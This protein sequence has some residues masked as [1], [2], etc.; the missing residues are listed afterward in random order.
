VIH[1]FAYQN[2]SSRKEEGM[3]TTTAIWLTRAG[4]ACEFVGFW[5]GIWELLGKERL[6]QLEK[7]LD[8]RLHRSTRSLR[9]SG[10]VGVVLLVYVITLVVGVIALGNV[11]F[12]NEWIKGIAI[13]LVAA[14]QMALMVIV[15]NLFNLLAKLMEYMAATDSVRALSFSL[16]AILFVIGNV[17]Q[18]L[19]TL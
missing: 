15:L 8:S 17:L 12:D 4:I 7:R 14:L 9:A 19:G 13:F 10:G 2:G 6:D 16:G 11:D 3:N 1:L 18:L 5:F